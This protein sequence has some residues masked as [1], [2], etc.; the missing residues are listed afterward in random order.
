VQSPAAAAVKSG[1]PDVLWRAWSAGSGTFYGRAMTVGH[2][3]PLAGAGILG[4][5]GDGGPA[6]GNSP[7]GRRG[8]WPGRAEAAGA[9]SRSAH[10]ARRVFVPAAPPQRVRRAEGAQR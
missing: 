3:Y 1:G 7:A 8:F 2:I 9:V 6:S 4:Q 10:G 5:S